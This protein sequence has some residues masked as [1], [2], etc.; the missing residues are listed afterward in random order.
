VACDT[1]LDTACPCVPPQFGLARVVWHPSGGHVQPK[2][3]ASQEAGLL[4]SLGSLDELSVCMVVQ[5]KD[6]E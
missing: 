3:V 2:N 6:L 1:I 4:V 5:Q